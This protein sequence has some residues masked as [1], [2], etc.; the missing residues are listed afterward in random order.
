MKNFTKRIKLVKKPG[1]KQNII[2]VRIPFRNEW[3]FFMRYNV[4]F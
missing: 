4:F 1:F 2:Y 3:D